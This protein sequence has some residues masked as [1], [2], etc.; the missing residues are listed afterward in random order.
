MKDTLTSRCESINLTSGNVNNIN[1]MIE[2]V[3]AFACC[4]AFNNAF[5]I[6]GMDQI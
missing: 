3:L 6:G 4:Q 1:T 2:P 5:L